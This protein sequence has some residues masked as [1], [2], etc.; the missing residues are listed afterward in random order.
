[1]QQLTL[2][3]CYFPSKILFFGEAFSA[4]N[5]LSFQFFSS[6]NS[7][8]NFLRQHQHDVD[9]LKRTCKSHA[10]HVQD[11]VLHTNLLTLAPLYAEVHNPC[12]F[13]ELSVLVVDAELYGDAA[14]AI[15]A[16]SHA[17][18]LKKLVLIEANEEPRAIAAMACGLIHAYVT[19]IA[20]EEWGQSIK[21]SIDQLRRAYFIDM[22]LMVQRAL[23]VVF[24]TWMRHH[25]AVRFFDILC[26]QN[27]IVEY[28]LMAVSGIFLLVNANA[29][30]CI[31]IVHDHRQVA[32]IELDPALFLPCVIG[33]QCYDYALMPVV[34]VLKFQRAHVLSYADYMNSSATELMV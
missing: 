3:A 5:D 26:Q 9:A 21:K 17:R 34:K 25:D 11:H 30:A 23:A 24:P 20:H 31:L 2:P 10:L 13:D 16:E 12:R 27:N 28:Y 22:S 14:W 8:L 33:N 18:A 1:M 6:Y 19:K 4:S 29:G 15:C 32:D 7:L